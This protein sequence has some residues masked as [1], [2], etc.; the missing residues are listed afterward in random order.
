MA[1]KRKTT[2]SGSGKTLV[3]VESPA[4][5]RTIGKFLGKDYSV[6]A[7]IGHIRDLPSGKKEMP[8]ALKKEPWARL[9]VNTEEE[10]KP[11]YVVPDEKKKQVSKLKQALAESDALYLATDEDREG[12]AISWHLVET[13]KPK[14]PVKRLVFHEITKSAIEQ[15]L[16]HP[17]DIDH[18]LVKAQETRRILDRLYGYEMSE[19]LW[20]KSLGRSAGRVQSV[21][22]RL[23]VERER[24]RMA[25]VSAS[26]W[27]LVGHFL[28]GS[29]EK[30][31][32]V[33]QSVDGRK[34][35][36]GKDFD[37]AT[38]KIKD[39]NFL[40]LNEQ[41]V[42]ELADR[43]RTAKFEVAG[44]EV[45]PYT[46]SPAAP[47][48]TST[49][50]Q[51][52]NRKLGFTARRTMNAAQS[53]Y[54]NGFITYM[55]TDSTTLSSEAVAAARKL[56]DAEYGRE[57]LPNEPRSYASKVKN[58]QEAHEAIRPTGQSFR[59]LNDVRR[60]LRDDEFR[61]Y[62]LIWKRTVA[63][64][65]VNSRGN[66]IVVTIGGGGAIFQ[67]SGK[68][69]EFPGFLRAYVEGS[70]DPA[71]DL[72]DQ[73]KILPAVQAGQ[74]LNCEQLEA[75]SHATQPP[76]RFS[77]AALTRELERRGIG[78]PSTYASIIDTIQA[79]N[80]VFKKGGYLVPSWSAFSVVRLLEEHFPSLVDYDFT[81][82]ME[83]VMDAISRDEADNVEYLQR[84][85]H[86]DLAGGGRTGLK[87]QL[88]VKLGEVDSREVCTFPL[89]IPA[90][91]EH[92]EPVNVRVGRYGPY[93]EQGSRTS[94]LRDETP[95]DELNLE[96]AL[97]LL[98]Q[99]QVGE[100]PLG[101]CPETG[102]PVYLKQGRFGPYVQLAVPEGE[103]DEKPKN[104]SLLKGMTPDTVTLET[105]LRLLSLPRDLGLNPDTEEP[106]LAYNG[107][108]GPYVK[109]GAETRSLPADLSVLDVSLEQAVELLRQPKA[110][111]RGRAR[112]AEPVRTFENSP[113]TNQ[114]IKL[115]NGRY[116]MYLTDG[117]TNATL[118][119]DVPAEGLTLELALRLLAERAAAGPSKK[120]ARSGSGAK[121][122]GKSAEPKATKKATKK[123]AK[124]SATK[125]ASTKAT[126]KKAVSPTE[127]ESFDSSGDEV[128]FDVD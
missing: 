93:L 8:D 51:E 10:F 66:N 123:A 23:L 54:E 75:K 33:L 80:Y 90:S 101:Y 42:R 13:L 74:P 63:S 117:E 14:V 97:E 34:I 25:F 126:P 28:T 15:A 79:R 27:D 61:L 94:P 120:K 95:P 60:E 69:I 31:D 38:G 57:Y 78:R 37:P 105:A 16:E 109:C 26:Y 65:M 46:R 30:L 100:E 1:A 55:R 104:A 121:R 128:P 73:E 106:V 70:D 2:G 85:Y 41:Q 89:G 82:Q 81:A 67:V 113:V 11:I 88:E 99:A 17:R 4:K 44:V 112:A 29:Q 5:A 103:E 53:L 102:R 125:K 52:A 22:V 24:E 62:E 18:G 9:G 32:A 68:T 21:A 50:Q 6:E 111:G 110:A 83:D 71:S 96:K 127:S 84:F 64:Q 20:K 49:L 124:K 122:A 48:T 58:A 19:F 36:S 59:M 45:K 115:L 3:I 77:E 43:L 107:K 76:A 108:F 47:F 40:L 12:E 35:P 87:N 119:K 72:A 92:L 114:P 91:G 39:S 86:G 56:V 7:S 98:N 116:G 118:P